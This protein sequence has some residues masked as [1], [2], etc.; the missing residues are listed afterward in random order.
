VAERLRATAEAQPGRT[1]GVLA[2]VAVLGIALAAAHSERLSLSG[3]GQSGSV[4]VVEVREVGPAQAGASGVVL[5]AMRARLS[6][7]PAVAAV[8]QRAGGGP[9]KVVLVA[10]LGAEGVDRQRALE[11]IESDLD[12]GPLQVSVSGPLGELRRARDETTGDLALLLL[13]LPLAALVLVGV[14]GLRPAGAAALAA[15]AAVATASLACELAGEPLDLSLLALA[16][17]ATGGT[18]VSLQLCAIAA[19]GASTRTAVLAGCAAGAAFGSL[20]LLGV[21]YLAAIGVGGALAALLAIPASVAA[22]S[23]V[24][25][26]DA[27]EPL[28]PR[29]GS[30]WGRIAALVSWKGAVALAI[31]LLAAATLLVQAPAAARL[32]PGALVGPAE[33]IEA[34]RLGA[35]AACA[36]VATAV[37]GWVVSRRPLLSICAAVAGALPALAVAGL[38]V[39][40]FQ[41]ERLTS[42]LDYG[43]GPVFLGAA[44]AALAT[45]AGVCASQAVSLAA[46]A[47]AAGGRGSSRPG[48]DEAMARCGPAATVTCLCG[49]AA[50]AALAVSSQP[51]V[52]QFGAALAAAML[53]QLL[54]VQGLIAPATLRLLTGRGGRE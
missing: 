46:A 25:A 7:D 44:V 33:A 6:A 38:L 49:A 47:R 16:G 54:L 17:T 45:T 21:G 15:G 4:L 27:G 40:V 1:L 32:E 35:A 19:A 26:L 43:G 13:A 37:L 30:V 42:V 39:L 36:L 20:A 24:A 29:G 5:R 31:A 10:R 48:G 23:A 51:F 34:P 28:R 14:L 22:V 53:L 2:A 41:D 8:H 11:R 12:P 50:G 9:G 3:S 52:K 18:L